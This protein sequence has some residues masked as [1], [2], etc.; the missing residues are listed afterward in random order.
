[1]TASPAAVT[2]AGTIQGIFVVVALVLVL[3]QHRCAPGF[4]SFVGF[5]SAALFTY[6]YVLPTFLPGYQDSFSSG[7][8]IN[9]YIGLRWRRRAANQLAGQGNSECCISKSTSA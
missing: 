9:G 3:R 4:A 6:A 8:R 7:P 1:M 5:G 2:A